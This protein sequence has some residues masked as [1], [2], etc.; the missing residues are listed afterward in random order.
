MSTDVVGKAYALPQA[1]LIGELEGIAVP[2][3][4]QER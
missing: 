2:L 4:G 3:P 1:L